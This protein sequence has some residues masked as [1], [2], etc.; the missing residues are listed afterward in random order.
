VT[1]ANSRLIVGIDLGNTNTSLAYRFGDEKPC[2]LPIDDDPEKPNSLRNVLR[3]AVLF[4]FDEDQPP[5][6]GRRAIQ[7]ASETGWL[8]VNYK[9]SL[10]QGEPKQAAYPGQGLHKGPQDAVV[11]VLR[12][13]R[14]RLARAEPSHFAAEGENGYVPTKPPFITLGVPA[15]TLDKYKSLLKAALISSGWYTDDTQTDT[16]VSFLPEPVAP[17]LLM[18]AESSKKYLTFD[19]GGLTLD[20][21]LAHISEGSEYQYKVTDTKR[22]MHEGHDIGGTLLDRLIMRAFAEDEET[23][24]ELLGAAEDA[25]GLSADPE[26]LRSMSRGEIDW[27]N[28]GT[29]EGEFFKFLSLDLENFR[30]TLS[31]KSKARLILNSFSTTNRLPIGEPFPRDDFD[32]DILEPVLNS[33]EREIN[34]ILVDDVGDELNKEEIMVVPAGGVSLTSGIVSYLRNFF[35]MSNVIPSMDYSPLVSI[36]MGCAKFTPA[37]MTEINSVR[38][39]SK[40]D[41]DYGV[42][43]AGYQHWS[44]VVP[45]GTEYEK[46]KLPLSL[47]KLGEGIFQTY[48]MTHKS[49]ALRIKVG[50]RSKSNEKWTLLGER[51]VSL[52]EN[53]D[54]FQVY[55]EIDPQQ[56]ILEMCLIHKGRRIP[57][58]NPKFKT[59]R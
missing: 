49:S 36:A 23:W 15:E 1:Q 58:T 51:T 59:P 12:D 53:V 18:S 30:I 57:M 7:L 54:D 45:E 14:R 39:N 56:G 32:R 34:A 26:K 44:T 47:P 28:D 17:L 41:T 37:G 10:L 9:K 8:F 33:I 38:V 40:T 46:T 25:Y 42:W 31:D 20:L 4:P 55:F 13:L 52:S 21:A 48:R 27:A 2:L 19:I 11:E 22:C 16:F 35:G 6:V 5:V 29:P 3:S 50:Q 43:D 24:L